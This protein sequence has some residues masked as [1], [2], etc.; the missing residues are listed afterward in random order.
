ML[1]NE[2]KSV[3][4]SW[5]KDI[6][7]VVVVALAIFLITRIFIQNY[8]IDGPSMEPNFY[9]G[10]WVIVSKLAYKSGSPHR[11]DVI[12]CK[13]PASNPPI[14]IKRVIG[15]PGEKVEITGGKIYIDGKSLNEGEYISIPTINGGKWTVPADSYFV[16]GDNRGN[17]SDSR[18]LGFIPKSDI[19]GKA[20]LRIWPLN[21]F[22]RAPNFLPTLSINPLQFELLAVKA[23]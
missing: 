4:W 9:T 16:L 15:L 14:L 20:W 23:S 11:G 1:E 21:K 5:I 22:G 7:I 10:Q 6:I 2:R 18:I 17:S 19:V 13:N 12:V 8:V 3:L